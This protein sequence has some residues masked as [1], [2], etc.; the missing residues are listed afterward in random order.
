M[1]LQ[2]V[3]NVRECKDLS[4]DR[5]SATGAVTKPWRCSPPAW[6]GRILGLGRSPPAVAAGWCVGGDRAGLVE[7]HLGQDRRHLRLAH[8]LG[9][10]EQKFHA[11]LFGDLGRRP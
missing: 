5:G 11:E 1:Y 7:I 6:R 9:H 10:L 4:S 3:A 2:F 8:A